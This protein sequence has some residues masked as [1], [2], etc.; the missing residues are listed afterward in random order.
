MHQQMQQATDMCGQLFS[1][2]TQQ[3]N[4]LQQHQHQQQQQQQQHQQ[5]QQQQQ[6]MQAAVRPANVRHPFVAEQSHLRPPAQLQPSPNLQPPQA[7]PPHPVPAQMPLQQPP[8]KRKA[9][10]SAFAVGQGAAASTPSPAAHTPG[11]P[12]ASTPRTNPP[13]TPAMASASSPS[14]PKSPKGKIPA[15]S[16]QGTAPAPK[17]RRQSKTVTPAVSA[18]SPSSNTSVK[19]HREEEEN[20]AEAE[21][22]TPSQVANTVANEPS[23]PKRIKTEW[24]NPPSEELQKKVEAVEKLETVDDANSFLEQVSELLRKAVDN[25][26]QESAL[27]ADLSET[28]GMILK[29]CA[30]V[31][32]ASDSGLSFGDVVGR[33]SPLPSTAFK[34][35]FE[36]FIDYSCGQ[37]DGP[38]D[39][40]HT[41]DLVSSSTNP[42]PESNADGENSHNARTSVSDIKKEDYHDLR[43]GLW[44]ELDGG[45]SAYYQP[46]EWKWDSPMPVLE[47][48]WAVSTS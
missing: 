25:E 2:L 40:E 47:Q 32:E 3:K 22:A 46:F 6:V 38:L 45:E 15:K 39:D 16:K 31:P 8:M 27:T 5:Q 42:S 1:A 37:P 17:Q 30:S 13:S 33:D 14:A 20:V 43:L 19:R 7:T 34:D 12:T 24:E 10:G 36:E 28:L 9:A 35:A 21:A 26:G 18:D 48:S 23:P 29:G 44:K 41:P 4:Q 11:P